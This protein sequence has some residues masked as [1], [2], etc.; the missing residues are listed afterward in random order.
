MIW[1]DDCSFLTK[2]WKTCGIV[3]SGFEGSAGGSL[4]SCGSDK[5]CFLGFFVFGGND[6]WV[7][8]TVMPSDSWAPRR[9]LLTDDIIGQY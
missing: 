5:D 9:L 8:R 3:S 1:P 6:E 2:G 4:V 7:N